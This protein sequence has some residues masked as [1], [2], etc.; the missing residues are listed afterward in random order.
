MLSCRLIV[1]SLQFIVIQKKTN[2]KGNSIECHSILLVYQVS[3]MM[4]KTSSKKSYLTRPVWII[5]LLAG[6]HVLTNYLV[7]R[8]SQDLNILIH[9]G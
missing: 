8:K 2:G 3:E 5:A 7:Y 4:P 6:Y 1:L 9:Q